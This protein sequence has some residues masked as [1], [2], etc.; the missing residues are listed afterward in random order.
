M[1]DTDTR[2]SKLTFKRGRRILLYVLGLPTFCLLIYFGMVFLVRFLDNQPEY[3]EVSIDFPGEK[4][5]W[6]ADRSIRTWD[7]GPKYFIWR[8]ET[9]VYKHSPDNFDTQ[10]SVVDFIDEQLA[11]NGWK[12]IYFSGWTPCDSVLPESTF[13]ER[14]NTYIEYKQKDWIEFEPA[15]P[16]LC[17]AVWPIENYDGFNVVIMTENPSE[18]TQWRKVLD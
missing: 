17:L 12:R 2:D 4:D 15:T 8:R 18:L 5:W 13:L 14:G 1:S 3:I 16:T 7:D 11:E 10:E 6:Y 9:T